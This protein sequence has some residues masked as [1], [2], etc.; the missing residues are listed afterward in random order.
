[1]EDIKG[2]EKLILKLSVSLRFDS[3]VFIIQLD[4]LARSIATALYTF[5]VGSLL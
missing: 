2:A 3:D 1:M 5:I 4:F